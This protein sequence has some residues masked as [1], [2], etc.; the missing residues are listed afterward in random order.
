MAKEN[1]FQPPED[2]GDNHDTDEWLRDHPEQ[3]PDESRISV[4]RVKD[5]DQE[6]IRRRAN[7]GDINAEGDEQPSVTPLAFSRND[8]FQGDEA[9]LD[10]DA[11]FSR[12][13]GWLGGKLYGEE[14]VG[15]RSGEHTP[16]ENAN[17]QGFEPS[18]KQERTVEAIARERA[19]QAASRKASEVEGNQGLAGDLR[20][21]GRDLGRREQVTAMQS[22]GRDIG[23]SGLPGFESDE[24]DAPKRSPASRHNSDWTAVLGKLGGGSPGSE[25]NLQ[26]AEKFKFVKFPST[27]DE[28]LQKLPPGAEFKVRTV[29][30]DLREAL[31]ECHTRNF[32]TMYDVIDCVKDSIRRAEK[33]E[34]HPA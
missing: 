34:R 2:A 30:V 13:S 7:V 23:S 32:R 12:G 10:T 16:I 26:L 33:L 3:A 14:S 1:L 20:D 5:V 4:D 19:A 28:I 15:G 17:P 29:T 25:E 18:E 24:G 9:S 8:D 27:Q 11:D 31:T 22:F 21:Q 6:S